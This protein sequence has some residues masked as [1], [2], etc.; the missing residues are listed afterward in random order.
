MFI[1][2]N[3][4]NF[5]LTFYTV[6]ESY[7]KMKFYESANHPI[8]FVH[9]LAQN[10]TWEDQILKDQTIHSKV[11]ILKNFC[12]IFMF[13]SIGL[14]KILWVIK[15]T[16]FPV[17]FFVQFICLFDLDFLERLQMRNWNRNYDRQFQYLWLTCHSLPLAE[18]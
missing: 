5:N 1:I 2:D 11:R 16:C 15:S 18:L 10:F 7:V 6:Q 3:R 17:N 14:G 12:L 13:F 4:K 9:S 8:S